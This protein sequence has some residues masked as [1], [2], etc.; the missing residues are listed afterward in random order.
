MAM[1]VLSAKDVRIS[2]MRMLSLE[3]FFNMKKVAAVSSIA[4]VTDPTTVKVSEI[5]SISVKEMPLG[6]DKLLSVR[7]TTYISLMPCYRRYDSVT[8]LTSFVAHHAFYDTTLSSP[9]VI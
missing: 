1:S 3:G 4:V 2:L 9:L 6:V 7:W 5:T 8:W